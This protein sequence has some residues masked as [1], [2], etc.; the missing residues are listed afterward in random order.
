[1]GNKVTVTCGYLNSSCYPPF[2]RSYYFDL[3][4]TIA[5]ERE[6]RVLINL[7]LL[8]QVAFNYY[9][10]DLNPNLLSSLSFTEVAASSEQQQLQRKGERQCQQ[11]H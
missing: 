10:I 9:E 3:N 5:K 6:K 2:H 7:I 1:M 11:V 4:A 8:F